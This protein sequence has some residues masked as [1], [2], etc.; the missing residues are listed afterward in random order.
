VVSTAVE[1]PNVTVPGRRSWSTRVSGPGPSVSVTVPSSD[2]VAGV[3]GQGDGL[4]GAGVDGRGLVGRGDHDVLTPRTEPDAVD[5]A[6]LERVGGAHRERVGPPPLPGGATLGRGVVDAVGVVVGLVLR[7][8]LAL[9]L[10]HVPGDGRAAVAGRRRPRDV[11]SGT[12][13][14]VWPVTLSAEHACGAPGTVGTACADSGAMTT[15]PRARPTIAAPAARER[16][17]EL[18]MVVPPIRV[19]WP[20]SS[21]R[22]SRS[23]RSR[24]A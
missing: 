11:S 13:T 23:R 14:P 19:S 12:V 24:P 16:L 15:P 17:D 10:H 3:A 6:D 7:G 5:R 22:L 18:F 20:G 1:L 2:A 4:V 21:R 9:D 8:R